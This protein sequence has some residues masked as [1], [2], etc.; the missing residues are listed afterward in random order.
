[1]EAVKAMIHDQDLSM[2]LWAEAARTVVYVQNRSPHKVLE[3]KTPEEVFFG[4]VPEV[5]H[6]RIFGC[7]VYIH[8]PKNKRTKFLQIRRVYLS[9]SETSKAYRVYPFSRDVIF[10]EDAVQIKKKLC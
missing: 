3:N 5:S 7:P 4:E 9:Y 1:M 6:L 8:I 10:D 2:Y